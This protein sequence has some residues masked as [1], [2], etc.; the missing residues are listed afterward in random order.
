MTSLLDN[1]LLVLT[2]G[3][4]TLV[5]QHML[6]W[7]K[8]RGDMHRVDRDADLKLDSQRDKLTMDLLAQAR[9]E[10]AS[11]RAE[12]ADLRPLQLR[13]AHLEEALDHVYAL[14]HADGP[15]EER[16]AHRRA[17]AFLKRMRPE[18]GDLRNIAQA[19]DSARALVRRMEEE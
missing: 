13:V 4:F 17:R 5:G 7:M 8:S 15:E 9:L 14:L 2:G 1:G 3:G 19:A 18:V 10:M 12:V 6:A 16:A 11:L